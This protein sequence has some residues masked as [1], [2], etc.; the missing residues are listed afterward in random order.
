MIPVTKP[1]KTSPPFWKMPMKYLPMAVSQP[2]CSSCWTFSSFCRNSSTLMP[3]S[4]WAR[5]TRSFAP[6]PTAS[7]PCNAA[8]ETIE[9]VTYRFWTAMS[10]CC[11]NIETMDISP[12]LFSPCRLYPPG[13]GGP[14]CSPLCACCVQAG[15]ARLLDRLRPRAVDLLDRPFHGLGHT[16]F[17]LAHNRGIGPEL[18]EGD[19]LEFL[20]SLEFGEHRAPG[21]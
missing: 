12:P 7:L 10:A 20:M 5:T 16:G 9:P 4:A 6:C 19:A 11:A 8:S 2:S 15:Q 14:L 13:S 1:A 21:H 18:I 3:P 17:P